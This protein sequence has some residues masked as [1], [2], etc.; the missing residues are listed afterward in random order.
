M[1]AAAA[2]SFSVYCHCD[3]CRRTAGAPVIASVAFVKNSITW[4]GAEMVSR[5]ENG[6]AARLF[7]KTCGSQIAQ[8]HDSRNDLTFFNTGF[9]DTPESY[10]PQHHSFAG[11]QISWLELNDDLPRHE[12]TLLIETK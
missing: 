12:K 3:D 2:P 7:C 10:P 5:Y 11:Q 8:E 4:S 9:M 6:T 1:E